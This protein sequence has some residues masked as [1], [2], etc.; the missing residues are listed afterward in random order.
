MRPDRISCNIMVHDN[1][2]GILAA[3]EKECNTG[4]TTAPPTLM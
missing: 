2:A 3:V 1:T 4:W